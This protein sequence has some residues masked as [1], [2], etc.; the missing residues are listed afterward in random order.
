MPDDALCTSKM[1]VGPGGKQPHMRNTIIPLDNPFG[2]CRHVQTLNYP[3]C[4]PE[5]HP[6]KNFEGK[7]KGMCVITEE[8]GY[9]VELDGGK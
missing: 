4:L 8:H 1:N 7:L 6:H 3:P 5:D 9:P 2:L